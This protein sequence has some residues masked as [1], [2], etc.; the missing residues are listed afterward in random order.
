MLKLDDYSQLVVARLIDFFGFN[1]SWQRRL[2]DVGTSLAL[3]ELL[4]ATEAVQ[5]GALSKA[6]LNRVI[7]SLRS[8]AL[9]DPAVPVAVK[10][11]VSDHARSE[12][13]F[14][15]H[16]YKVLQQQIAPLE[17]DYLLRWAGLV[18]DVEKRPGPDWT[19]AA[20]AS[21]LLD[22]G[23]NP[24]YLYRWC[25]YRMG[26]TSP[27]Q[28]LGELLEEANELAGRVPQEWEVL[29]AFERAPL[30]ANE[31]PPGWLSGKGVNA[32]LKSNEF[33]PVATE[34]F[35]GLVLHLV[36]RDPDAA[37]EQASGAVD[38][39]GS[40]VALA[41]KRQALVPLET[42][43]VAGRP[44]SYQLMRYAR[45]IEARSLDSTDRMYTFGA[46]SRV[47]EAIQLLR[48][49]NDGAPESAVASGWAAIETLFVGPG[50]YSN[51]I[52][53]GERAAT[54]AACSLPRAELTTIAYACLR[55]GKDELAKSIKGAG[56]S[57]D[58]ASL[59]ADAIIADTISPPR[60]ADRAAASRMKELIDDPPRELRKIRGYMAGA[61]ARL[62]RQRNLVLHWGR[63]EP[64]A[65][66]ASLRTA[67][68]LVGAA[69]DRAVFAWGS[70]RLDPLELAARARV[71]MHGLAG[72]TVGDVLMLLEPAST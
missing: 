67:A 50:D 61:I 13:A 63:T 59:V 11:I 42:I 47:D 55:E 51:R 35:G 71:R 7:A 37:V 62:Y 60:D 1:T 53:G 38:R 46:P 12:V 57:L 33:D 48:P 6:A 31:A 21:H 54:I 66:S 30:P 43:W 29:V 19:A 40:R 58:R 16:D 15:G 70:E 17:K 44:R 41:S 32:W 68:P 24:N 56:S 22:I 4:E 3:R 39:L 20:I 9:S 27:E 8:A 25:E 18:D 69:L 36:A 52:A 72:A 64:V 23:H 49:L 5:G 34:V 10:S 28:T 26:D 14:G 65:L 45:G 2:W